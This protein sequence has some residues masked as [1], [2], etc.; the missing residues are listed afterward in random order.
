MIQAQGPVRAKAKG[1]KWPV[2][3]GWGEGGEAISRDKGLSCA[4]GSN[5]EA[6]GTFRGQQIIRKLRFPASTHW[7]VLSFF[8]LPTFTAH[9]PYRQG[10]CVEM[11]VNE[12]HQTVLH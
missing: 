5:R 3:Q 11:G 12:E 10:M 7:F 9:P 1:V 2:N 4:G 8:Y 6:G